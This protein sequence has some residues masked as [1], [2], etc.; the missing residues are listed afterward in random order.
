[1]KEKVAIIADRRDYA[2]DLAE[3]F[4]T[5]FDAVAEFKDYGTSDINK[6]EG[7]VKEKLVIVSAYSVAQNIKNKISPTQKTI[8]ANLT[9]RKDTLYMLDDFPEN[10][11]AYLVNITYQRCM[12]T[13]AMLYNAMS[14]N[15]NLIPF[16]P[17]CGCEIDPDIDTAITVGE[18]DL[19]PKGIH[20]VIDLGQRLLA[21]SS[22][23]RCAELL[24]VENYQDGE[25]V[26]KDIENQVEFSAKL[27]TLIGKKNN[28]LVSF[29]TVL[30]LVRQGIIIVDSGGQIL[31]VSKSAEKILANQ[32]NAIVGFSI[33][34]L[35]PELQLTAVVRS[36]QNP[37]E[38]IAEINK[39]TVIITVSGVEDAEENVGYVIML[40]YF[41]EAEARQ[42]KF[43]RRISGSGHI[44]THCFD[45]ILGNS[46]A[47]IKAKKTAGQM[48]KS[49]SNVCI[50]GESGTGK[51]LF[52]Q[53][54]HNASKRR[55]FLFVAL[56]CSALPENLLES[57]LF[58]YEG[59]AFSGA[60][61]EGKIGMLELAHKGT[62][63]LDEIGELPLPMQA[64]L[65][66]VLEEK[67]IQ[68]V[69]GVNLIN[70]DI[71][72]ICAT[73]RNLVKM[74]EE[75][76]FRRDLYYRLCVLPLSIPPLRGRKDDIPLLIDSFKEKNNARYT[77]SAQAEEKLLQYAWP[78]NVR[79]L[80]NTTEYLSSLEKPVIDIE[81]IS[82]LGNSFF[83]F[84]G[85][86][87]ARADEQKDISL[88]ILEEIEKS[89]QHGRAIGRQALF[90]EAAVQGL[91]FTE[92]EIRLTMRKLCRLGYI[93]SYQ[94][95]RG[96]ELTDD[97]REKI[98]AIIGPNGRL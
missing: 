10:K 74:I 39:R 67:K 51:E 22:I 68:K 20:T 89:Q 88:F 66:R 98:Q 61:N 35:F 33:F 56:N 62:I 2:K 91:P 6:I 13:M 29:N 78:G 14:K 69:G 93:V 90:K 53:A 84:E 12:E 8:I 60:K 52:A 38:T 97:G 81:D 76:S 17:G 80:R 50:Y 64:K 63:F 41:N 27:N 24:G 49:D 7:Y 75:G 42:H 45:D 59:G 72:V 96:S 86:M 70:V 18:K 48:A 79:E 58:G 71:R 26:K 85:E 44:A 73:N 31:L 54:I 34:D 16:Y 25:K 19:V 87:E 95:R 15:I 77:L 30:A 94:G 23:D 40:E 83:E 65:L 47:I 21:K 3:M 28:L 37:Y 43:R 1:M 82:I 92:T 9:L 32:E 57:E 36:S 4:G 5:Y 46:K 55:N 11:K